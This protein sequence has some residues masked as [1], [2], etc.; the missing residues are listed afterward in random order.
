MHPPE[1]VSFLYSRPDGQD[2]TIYAAHV[3]DD[4][5]FV[6]PLFEIAQAL[7][8]PNPERVTHPNAFRLSFSNLKNARKC[9][10]MDALFTATP[11]SRT[12]TGH[13]PAVGP[14]IHFHR[15]LRAVVLPLL[16]G[17]V[18]P[19]SDVAKAIKIAAWH[20]SEARRH[21]NAAAAYRDFL[22]MY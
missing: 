21:N 10:G 16:D 18:W 1:A 13:E 11:L 6:F 2:V 7:F 17:N 19:P 8:Y 3:D 12:D 15:W 4:D 14:A 5:E 22:S 9:V 20:E